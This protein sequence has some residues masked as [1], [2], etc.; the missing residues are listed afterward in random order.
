MKQS[1]LFVILA[2]ASLSCPADNTYF[3][4]ILLE[5][6]GSILPNVMIP[7]PAEVEAVGEAAGAAQSASELAALSAA[8]LSSTLTNLNVQVASLGGAQIV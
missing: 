5:R 4:T 3:G 7:T 1:L 2:C 6:N 8:N